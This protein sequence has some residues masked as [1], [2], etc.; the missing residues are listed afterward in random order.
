MPPGCS[1]PRQG[2]PR[3]EAVSPLNPSGYRRTLRPPCRINRKESRSCLLTVE[4]SFRAPWAPRW[5]ERSSVPRP[6]CSPEEAQPSSRG[7][8]CKEESDESSPAATRKGSRISSVMTAWLQVREVFPASFVPQATT[9]SAPVVTGT[10]SSCSPQTCRRSS[11][12]RG[13]QFSLPNLASHD[14]R[15]RMAHDGDRG[16]QHPAQRRAGADGR[17]WRGHLASGRRRGSTQHRAHDWTSSKA[18]VWTTRHRRSATSPTP[19]AFTSIARTPTASCGRTSSTH[20][21]A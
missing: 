9:R 10:L 16:L 11:R 12:R 1:Q 5:P 6:R 4:P 15:A 2:R 18:R 21:R 19:S 8:H 13:E 17:C 14:G 3:R 20:A 7:S